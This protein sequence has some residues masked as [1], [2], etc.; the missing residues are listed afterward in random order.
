VQISLSGY[1]RSGPRANY[2]AY[3]SNI[4][5]YIGLTEAWGHNPQMLSDY[6]AGATAALAGLAALKRAREDGQATYIDAAQIDAMTPI[7]APLLVGSAS[8]EANTY[9]SGSDIAGS[10]LRGVYA[11]H[12]R[13]YVAIELEDLEDWRCACHFVG[14]P[15]LEIA[16]TEARPGGQEI[17]IPGRDDLAK[18]LA[19]WV[20]TVT[21]LTAQQ[22]LQRAGLAA[23]AVQ[24]TEDIWRD[25][26]LR[27]RLFASRVTQA[28]F[29]S[30]TYPG[31]G[32][33]SV[34]AFTDVDLV[35]PRLGEHTNEVLDDWLGAGAARRA[36][37]TAPTAVFDAQDDLP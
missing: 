33:H 7:M 1:G 35:P 22:L 32:W 6:V 26:Q 18:A 21:A 34:P 14:R 9:S 10:L 13:G 25:P 2:L 20:I 27:E 11:T 5:S 37:L 17:G 31:P 19:E 36:R 24:G 23:G 28:D 30:I 16:S 3:A 29:G 8:G 12:D 4:S 15:D